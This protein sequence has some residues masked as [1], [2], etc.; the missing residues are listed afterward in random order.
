MPQTCTHNRALTHPGT[1]IKLCVS[2][3]QARSCAKRT[4]TRPRTRPPTRSR[5]RPCAPTRAHA[6]ASAQA[7]AH[8]HAPAPAHASAHAPPHEP[9]PAHTLAPPT[10]RT[11]PRRHP[12]PRTRPHRSP[13]THP[14]PRTAVHTRAPTHGRTLP[15]TKAHRHAR[16]THPNAHKRKQACAHGCTLRTYAYECAHASTD[17][18]GSTHVHTLV[19]KLPRTHARADAPI[20]KVPSHLQAVSIP[21]FAD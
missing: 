3:V 14:R 5:S 13:R 17:A 15:R 7:P 19:H 20:F 8:A 2:V 12:R 6:H 11:H 1:H 16:C 18:L 9:A 21:I 4:R 10:M